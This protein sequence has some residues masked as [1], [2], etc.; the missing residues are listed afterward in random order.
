MGTASFS[1]RNP[2]EVGL[3][4]NRPLVA[5]HGANAVLGDGVEALKKRTGCTSQI[6]RSQAA[7]KLRSKSCQ[8]NLRDLFGLTLLFSLFLLL[9]TRSLFAQTNSSDVPLLSPTISGK[10]EQST[11]REHKSAAQRLTA[12]GDPPQNALE[13]AGREPGVTSSKVATSGKSGINQPESLGTS[14]FEPASRAY[15]SEIIALSAGGDKSLIL[16]LRRGGQLSSINK[17][18]QVAASIQIQPAPDVAAFFQ[19]EF[20]ALA[21]EGKVSIQKVGGNLLLSTEAVL[22]SRIPTRILSLRFSNNGESLYIGGADGMVYRWRFR[23]EQRAT[24][25]KDKQRCF[26]RYV[27]ASSSISAVVPHPQA[28]LFFSADWDGGLNAWVPYDADVFNGAYDENLFAG[29][30][31]TDKVTRQRAARPNGGALQDLDVSA[32]GRWLFACTEGGVIE[33]WK[34]R[35]FA[36]MLRAE[37][38]K[39]D[40]FD[41][42][43]LGD[44]NSFAVIHRD[45]TLRIILVKERQ[46]EGLAKQEVYTEIMQQQYVKEPRVL[47][48]SNQTSEVL[49]GNAE[50]QVMR[51]S[52]PQS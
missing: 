37:L 46:A 12:L 33:V 28:R 21:V 2:T 25:V 31:Y 49:V 17:Q 10:N 15:L 29:R 38:A 35:G 48:F 8:P 22:S 43:A 7:P 36:R 11:M 5:S 26:E 20:L 41:I 13:G 6:I 16:A 32:K 42:Q 23:D 47:A 40:C 4:K 3:R 44:E 18:D 52:V 9:S 30:G 19:G 34:V 39:G 1:T 14:H 51:F 50:G 24:N 45:G 27:G